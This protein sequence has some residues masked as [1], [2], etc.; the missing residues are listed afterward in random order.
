ML[1]EIGAPATTGFRIGIGDDV[2]PDDLDRLVVELS[3]T[4]RE[5]QRI[6]TKATEAL[7]RFSGGRGEV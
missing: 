3:Q 5:L 2:G 4:V 6:E 1:A 7:T